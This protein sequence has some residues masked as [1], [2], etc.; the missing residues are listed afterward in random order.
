MVQT[1]LIP[2]GRTS[3]IRRG[4]AELQI[5]TEYAYRPGPRLTTSV[6]SRGQV[7][8]KIQ[9][10]LDSPISSLDEKS[11]VERLLQKQHLEVIEVVKGQNFSTDITIKEKPK[12]ERRT[13]TLIDQIKSLAGVEKVYRVDNEGNFDSPHVSTDFKK[14]FSP[15]FKSLYEIMSIFDE[16][17]GG[18]RQKGVVRLEKNRLYLV[19]SGQECYFVLARRIAHDKDYETRLSEILEKYG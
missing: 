16:L 5:Q 8:H 12:I 17:P 2:A 18:Q 3:R 10:D 1:D 7:I 4:S 11:R 19:S 9:Q 13:L 6:I 14:S 15:V